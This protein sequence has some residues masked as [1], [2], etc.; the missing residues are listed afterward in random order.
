MP[1]SMSSSLSLETSS[2]LQRH[3]C[4]VGGSVAYPAVGNPIRLASIVQGG[5]LCIRKKDGLGNGRGGAGG[6]VSVAQ[7]DA[8]ATGC[9]THSLLV[10]MVV[11]EATVV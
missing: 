1:L 5:G 11:S 6:V 3:V 7:T 10:V 4:I 9:S 2:K 8:V